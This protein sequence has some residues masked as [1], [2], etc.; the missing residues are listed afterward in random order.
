VFFVALT[1]R[2][3]TGMSLQSFLWLGGLLWLAAVFIKKIKKIKFF[4][5]IHQLRDYSI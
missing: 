1:S 3:S 2:I 5:Q 4:N